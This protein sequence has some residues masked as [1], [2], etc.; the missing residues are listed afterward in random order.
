MTAW[1]ILITGSALTQGTAWAH[2]N[3]RLPSGVVINEGLQVDLVIHEVE[4]LVDDDAVVQV[5]VDTG[6][7][8][9]HVNDSVIYAEVSN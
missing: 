5:N 6:I 8:E 1:Q 7:I 3:N 4:V 2:F 9:V